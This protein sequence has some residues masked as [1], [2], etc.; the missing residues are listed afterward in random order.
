MELKLPAPCVVVLIGPSRTGKTTWA[1][2]HFADSEVVSSDSLRAMV[3]IDEDDQIASTAAFNLLDQIVTERIN[4]HLTTVIDTTGLNAEDRMGWV[5]MA[6]GADLPI[7][8]V[9]FTSTIE[10][11]QPLNEARRRPIPKTVL[12]KQFSGFNRAVKEIEGESFDGVYEEQPIRAV[13]STLVAPASEE[14]KPPGGAHLRL[15]AEQ[16]RVG[17]TGSW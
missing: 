5:E 7:Y 4:R 11:V 14:T 8:A 1:H 10:S 15:A 16:V 9:L 17:G 6:H 12:R 3:G 13:I 2:A